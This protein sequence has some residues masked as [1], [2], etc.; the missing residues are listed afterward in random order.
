MTK[1]TAARSPQAL[2]ELHDEHG[3]HFTNKHI[4]AI[5][6]LLGK[7]MDSRKPAF[8]AAQVWVEDESA[9]MVEALIEHSTR[10]INAGKLDAWNLTNVSQGVAKIRRHAPALLDAISDAAVATI[11]DFTAQGLANTSWSY[12]TAGHEA[13]D[14]FAAVARAVPQQLGSFIPRHYNNVLWAFVTAD[15]DAPELFDAIAPA[16]TRRAHEFN[17][18]GL[19]ITAWAY[20]A[21]M[22]SSPALYDSIAASAAQKIDKIYHQELANLAWAFAVHDH[23]APNLFNEGCF[24]RRCSELR[25]DRAKVDGVFQLHQWALWQQEQGSSLRLPT[26]IAERARAAFSSRPAEPSILQREV[27]DELLEMLSPAAGATSSASAAASASTSGESS[28][29]TT[30][31]TTTTSHMAPSSASTASRPLRETAA[32]RAVR[33]EVT[34]DEGY[35]VDLIVEY[36]DDGEGEGRIRRIGVE[37]D[38]PSH[39]IGKTQRPTGGTSLKQRQ[40]ERLGG[41]RM[42]SVPYW[43]WHERKSH[44]SQRRREYLKGLLDEAAAR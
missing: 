42:V 43:E 22:H 1:L 23:A 15:Y 12:A 28:S 41:L 24:V 21:T 6:N 11:G 5:W 25:W 18:Q 8:S 37:V 40:L 31:T 29:A 7:L 26:E 10:Q 14:L 13:P 39:Y 30:T 36:D 17:A 4:S 35:S 33:E 16:A 44:D 2:L 19:G 20:A 32:G 27:R 9:D 3:E 38:G 34:T